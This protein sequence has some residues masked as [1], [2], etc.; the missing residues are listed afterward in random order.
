VIESGLYKWAIANVALQ[1]LLGQSAQEKISGL[2][3]AFYYSFLPK[4]PTL[5]A[6]VLDRLKAEEA[7]DTLDARSAAP[8]TLIEARFQFGCFANDSP[9]NPA[10]P[11][12]YLSAAVLSQALRLQIMALANGR[13]E[14]PDGTVIQDVRIDDEFDAHFE[15]GGQSYLYRRMLM[16][17]MIYVS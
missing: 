13:A 9:E 10:N 8:G 16:V 15:L 2:Y 7:D 3:S 4:D 1:P 17:T 6:I 14:L 5:P 11:S 12:G